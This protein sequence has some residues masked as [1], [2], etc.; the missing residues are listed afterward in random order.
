[1][2]FQVSLLIVVVTNICLETGW[3]TYD[4]L[5]F[6]VVELWNSGDLEDPRGAESGVSWTRF[7]SH[8]TLT[9]SICQMQDIFWMGNTRNCY[10][11][12]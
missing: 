1:M 9:F 6:L 5:A 10:I 2:G 4:A 11:P 3:G 12:H 7:D 8:F